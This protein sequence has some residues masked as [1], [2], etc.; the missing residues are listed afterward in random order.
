MGND[1]LLGGEGND[2]LFGGG[3]SDVLIGGNGND[4]LEA[5][6]Q[7]DALKGGAGND[8]L[9]GGS[10][11]DTYFIGI[12]GGSDT[13]FNFDED[14]SNGV[15]ANDGIVFEDDIANTEL[16]FQK[17]G[18]DL[19]VTVIRDGTKTT[20]KDW[21]VNDVTGDYS[22]L[23]NFVV[24]VVIAKQHV[25]GHKVSLPRLLQLME[26]QAIPSNFDS[27]SA[28][29][30]ADINAAWRQNQA[31]TVA[32]APGQPTT[33]KEDGVLVFNVNIS[34]QETS[35][36]GLTL[37]A[38]V[39]GVLR[40]AEINPTGEGTYTVTIRGLADQSGIGQLM[41]RAFDGGI[42]SDPLLVPITITPE[43]DGLLLGATQ[44][45]LAVNAGTPVVLTGLSAALKD[46][47]G[48]EVIEDLFVDGLPAGAILSS[49]TQSFAATATNGSVNIRGWNGGNLALT[50][51]NLTVTPPPGSGADFTLRLRG[52]SRDGNPGAYVYSTESVSANIQIVVN[53]PP[54]GVRLQLAGLNENVVGGLVGTLG[55][56]GDPDRTGNYRYEIIGGAD[57][58]RFVLT[59]ANN[60]ELRLAAGQAL[61]F[62]AP[63]AQLQIRVVDISSGTELV[64]GTTEFSITPNNVNEAP[65]TP[66]EVTNASINDGAGAGTIV[67]NLNLSATDDDGHAVKFEIVGESS[68]FEVV[69]TQVRVRDGQVVN[70]EG[71][72]GAT[73]PF[74]D[75]NIIARDPGNLASAVARTIRVN[76]NPVDEAPSLVLGQTAVTLAETA[77]N[78]WGGISLNGFDQEGQN[79]T[80]EIQP[81]GAAS[82]FNVSGQ[83]A[84]GMLRLNGPL[85]YD[86]A[87]AGFGA[88][89]ASGVRS[90]TIF[91][92]SRTSTGPASDYQAFTFNLSNVDEAPSTPA[93]V[94]QLIIDE[95]TPYSQ[96][97]DLGSIDPE[98][99]P[100]DYSFALQNNVSGNPG[101]LFEI[102][103]TAGSGLTIKLLQPFDFET[104]KNQS[105]Y[106]ATNATSGTITLKIVAV[107]ADINAVGIS[108]IADSRRSLARD[109]TVLVR[110][111]DEA[112]LNPT[113]S[114]S[115]IN[116][117][118]GVTGFTG[119]VLGATDVD[120]STINYRFAN[121]TDRMGN[122]F[123]F[124]NG[125]HVDGNGL[126]FEATNNGVLEFDIFAFA[127]GQFSKTG[128]RQKINVINVND[129]PT[130][131]TNVPGTLRITENAIITGSVTSPGQL[132]ATD[133][134]NLG[135]TYSI[136][137]GNISRPNGPVFQIDPKT[138]VI[139]YGNGGVDYEDGGWS[140]GG[141]TGKFTDLIIRASD[142]GT[143]VD[144]VVR[145]EV[146][147]IRREVAVREVEQPGYTFVTDRR[148]NPFGDSRTQLVSIRLVDNQGRVVLYHS[149]IV[150]T[151]GQT[152]GRAITQG[153]LAAGYV[154][155][156]NGNIF[157]DDESN[158]NNLNHLV[159]SD[160]VTFNPSPTPTPT[161]IGD[162]PPPGGVQPPI[163]FDLNGDGL[164]L[165][166]LEDSHVLF[167]QN[168]DGILDR[169]GFVGADDALLVYDRNRN[170]LI[171]NGSE[172]SFVGDKEGAKTDLEGLAGFD[173]DGD[174]LITAKDSRF[175]ELQ[176]WQDRNQDGISQVDELRTLAQA[177]IVSI[178]LGG[179]S[180]GQTAENTVGNIV[181]NTS[182][183][184]RSDGSTG[185][186]GDVGLV[187]IAGSKTVSLP[188][189]AILTPPLV[190]VVP[191]TP[192]RPRSVVDSAIPEIIAVSQLLADAGPAKPI[193]LSSA[194]N[195]AD[196]I[197]SVQVELKPMVDLDNMNMESP[198]LRETT[199]APPPPSNV[200]TVDFDRRAKHFMVSFQQGGMS[201]APRKANGTFDARAGILGNTT[202]LKFRDRAIG[203]YSPVVLDLDGDG[204]ELRS[205]KKSHAKFDVDGDGIKD[206]TGWVGRGDGLLVIDRNN[207]GLITRS[208]ELLFQSDR[209]ASTNSFDALAEFDD[210][211]DGRITLVD[212]RFSDLKIWLDANDNGETDA[213]ELRSLDT[214][215]ITA[216][217]LSE[218]ATN[219]SVKVG[220]NLVL[221]TS[222]FTKT[223]GSTGTIGSVGF[224]FAASSAVE[225]TSG[226]QA[227]LEHGAELN[228]DSRR[229]L[230]L[231]DN[232]LAALR[233]GFDDGFSPEDESTS[234]VAEMTELGDVRLLQ[235]VQAMSVFGANAASESKIHQNG[236]S[237]NSMDW[238]A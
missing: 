109:I 121:G 118:E 48:S 122:L 28:M 64:G 114:N 80:Y 198:A 144:Q 137:G 231:A 146:V 162:D 96:N 170:G 59:G 223:N 57:Q 1:T 135:I 208:S 178:K 214:A 184:S 143:P 150:N 177:G 106:T 145:V 9:I 97:F 85:D 108:N 55:A 70:F 159:G 18:R 5:G 209:S 210:N 53:A 165:I 23:D 10:G 99:G 126:D 124:G 50:L 58:N 169:T 123:L 29:L 202:I 212:R 205:R 111:V 89:N 182:Q 147:N 26:G 90:T 102:V 38:L 17:S 112:P 54:T 84:G 156:I 24:D 139:G 115:V 98:G 25:A 188:D 37:E 152:S 179:T 228:E 171:D 86:G 215:G 116:I 30:Q 196:E 47:D 130:V 67:A 218:Q 83:G 195:T 238:F 119:V 193:T 166:S 131:F 88:I 45:A 76:I 19:V 117:T 204:L 33:V 161:P 234:H 69:G 73:I 82:L 141:S 72:N 211:A 60:S 192:I 93:A 222:S 52:R 163:V 158:N 220:R 27:L 120:S 77:T 142:G 92:R 224:A 79:V 140:Q 236:S 35:P 75:L 103:N 40:P 128:V 39:D 113:S 20:I 74:H 207:D 44:T 94:A 91:V 21:F 216:I 227:I 7:G 157:S 8:V 148:A 149:E 36:S 34:D 56:L 221:A 176:V 71:V 154:R 235:M 100:V 186:L 110:N 68:L 225:R 16:W 201:I 125:L 51:S 43:A 191:P 138:G 65:G 11:G 197:G 62:E 237:T 181:Y 226:A 230:R 41:L 183:F 164:D 233:N 63:A 105:Y 132:Q 32:L 185:L 133:V 194:A 160:L 13:I 187:Y 203:I 95:N 172:I 6:N 15:V 22:A 2:R 12:G 213:G 46:A 49:G 136:V 104:I 127:D 173:T 61:N 78:G 190:N 175:A 206:N 180:T 153:I 129:N 200:Q 151:G 174:A 4:I 14:I 217:N 81:G 87:L 167:D 229:N 3:Q 168:G 107:D 189:S 134:D 219:Q 101:G 232:R 42:Y 31:P 66:A 155:D 199:A